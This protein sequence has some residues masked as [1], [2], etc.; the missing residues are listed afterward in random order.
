MIVPV[1][2]LPALQWTT[3]MF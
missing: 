3:T 1:L 2:P